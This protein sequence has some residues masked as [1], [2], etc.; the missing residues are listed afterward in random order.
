[1]LATE[2]SRVRILARYCWLCTNEIPGLSFPITICFNFLSRFAF[3][4]TVPHH[5]RHLPSFRQNRQ[6]CALWQ[7]LLWKF[8]SKCSHTYI[9]AH[10][11]L[12][13]ASYTLWMIG[14]MTR[15][16]PRFPIQN[17]KSSPIVPILLIHH[18]IYT[19]GDV[20]F[21]FGVTFA[22]LDTSPKP[23]KSLRRTTASKSH[24]KRQFT[25]IE[26]PHK[27]FTHI[28]IHKIRFKHSQTCPVI[29]TN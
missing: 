18:K 14:K 15:R 27:I 12:C 11:L 16:L 7:N 21:A 10:I 22:E 26:I 13:H 19:F 6:T 23:R 4:E 5:V 17:E 3:F 28:H 2:W 24:F 25:F 9:Y 20:S 1:M 29:K 8:T